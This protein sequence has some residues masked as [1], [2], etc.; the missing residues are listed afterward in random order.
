MS[1][2]YCSGERRNKGK[3]KFRKR[4]LF[5][6]RKGGKFRTREGASDTG[7]LGPRK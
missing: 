3:D 4:K 6:Y 2:D 1:D 5:P 7:V